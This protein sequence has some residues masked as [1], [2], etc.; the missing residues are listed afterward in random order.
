MNRSLLDTDIFSEVLKERNQAVARAAK[1]YRAAFVRF[2][3]SAITVMEI[4]EGLHKKGNFGSVSRFMEL[5][6]ASEVLDFDRPAAE[7]AGTISADLLKTGQPIGRAD[8]MIAAIAIRHGLV[9]ATANI[10]HFERVQALGYSLE[11]A[12]WRETLPTP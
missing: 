2:T 8:P 4:V 12:N 1:N 7:L 9:L 10:Q 3:I 5:V 6:D 11:L